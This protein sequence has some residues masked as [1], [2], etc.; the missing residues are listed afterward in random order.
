MALKEIPK[1]GEVWCE[2][3]RLL[4]NPFNHYFDLNEAEKYLEFGI[5]FTPQYGDSFIELLKIYL[6]RGDYKKIK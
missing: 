6:I 2:G 4:M 1:S 3:A 5:F